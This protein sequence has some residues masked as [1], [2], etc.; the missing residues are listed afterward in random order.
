MTTMLLLSQSQFGQEQGIDK[1]Q[2]Q[3]DSASPVKDG[4]TVLATCVDSMQLT[5]EVH[6]AREL[7]PI[8]KASEDNG[9]DNYGTEIV[10]HGA[11]A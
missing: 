4:C 1:H 3:D 10:Q 7:K 9:T 6:L 2:A 8:H 11:C 5:E